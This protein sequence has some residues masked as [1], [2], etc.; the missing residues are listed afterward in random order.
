MESWDTKG[1]ILFS[2]PLLGVFN[3]LPLLDL[4]WI[5]GPF[6]R[7]KDAIGVNAR[8]SLWSAGRRNSV[9]MVAKPWTEC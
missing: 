8:F 4:A 6:S 2:F 9:R 1:P 3:H 7:T 5:R